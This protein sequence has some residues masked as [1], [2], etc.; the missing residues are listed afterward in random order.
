MQHQYEDAITEYF[1]NL[2]DNFIVMIDGSDYRLVTPFARLDGEYI[3]LRVCKKSVGEIVITDDYSTSD[4]L[5][6]NGLTWKG[7]A[8]LIQEVQRITCHYQVD[9]IA[10][11]LL[12]T[13]AAFQIGAG[14]HRLLA[15]TLA[16]SDLVYKRRCRTTHIFST[17]VES[18]FLKRAILVA[19]DLAGMGLVARANT[20]G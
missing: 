7:N 13:V 4:Y 14:L 3:E 12:V 6:L 16:L 17:E 1:A 9:F 19:S 20:I 18:I 2:P 5:F 8:E 11:E 15:A 10:S